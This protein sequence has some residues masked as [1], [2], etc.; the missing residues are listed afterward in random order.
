MVDPLS[1]FQY[2]PPVTRNGTLE[3]SF[4]DWSCTCIDCQNNQGL[5]RK[6]RTHFDSANDTKPWDDEMYQLCPPRTLGYILADKQW[7]QLQ[8]SCINSIPTTDPADAWNSR[9]QLADDD[10][11][12]LLFNLVRSHVSPPPNPT[13][14]KKDDDYQNLEVDDIVPGKGKGLVILLYGKKIH[15]PYGCRILAH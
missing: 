15:P 11:K 4:L 9:L 10:T 8:I 6:Y 1:Y 5:S 2:G 7:A 14:R 13:I 3:P 12:R